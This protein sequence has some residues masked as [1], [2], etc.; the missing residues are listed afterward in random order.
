MTKQ[1]FS[2]FKSGLS[3]SDISS[4]H[5]TPNWDIPEARTGA[6]DV[7]S[8][9]VEE[10]ARYYT[11]LSRPKPSNNP[12]ILIDALKTKGLKDEDSKK[13]ESPLTLEEVKKAMHSMAKGKSPGPDGLGAEFYHAFS[14]MVAPRLHQMLLEAQ[15]EGK[16]PESFAAG[17]ISVLYKKGDPRDVRNYRP[18]TLLQVDYKIYSKVLVKRMKTVIDAFVSKE[19]LGF[20]PNRNIAEA[21]HLT[22]LIQNYLD[23]KNEDG[24]LLALDWEKAF[25]RCSW[26]YYHSALE[27][28]NFGPKFRRMLLLLAN[29]DSPA[30]RNVK[31]NGLRS[32]TYHIHCGVPQGCPFSPLAF[33]VVA[34]ALTRLILTS[35]DFHGITIGSINHRISQFADDTT[36]FARD[37][38]DACHIWPILDLYEAATGMRANA[39]K[40]LG[41]QMG[42]LKN[43]SPPPGFGPNGST[44][45]MLEDGKFGKILGIPF[46]KSGDEDTYWRGLYRKIKTR[47]ASWSTKS[48]LTIHARVQL[49]NLICYGIPRYWIQSIDPPD[50]FNKEIK[51]DIEKLIWDRQIDFDPDQ[52]GSTK[53][54]RPWIK[55]TAIYHPKRL[56]E[57]GEG[58]GL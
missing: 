29:P 53:F 47:M 24:L 22:K 30:S 8:E 4:L 25:D 57:K 52:G 19:Q 41:I 23:D 33:L 46:W 55:K 43:K 35:E 56:N 14:S 20:V 18:I 21:T 17:D 54:S 50:W 38:N 34:E 11:H 10:F 48:F 13:L 37:Y 2:Q 12:D 28:L 31:I 51:E 5:T 9:I 15:D 44:I 32:S 42:S 3:N 39:T 45:E 7:D 27:A 1:F 49:A 58:L 26:Q 40:F 6:T 16:F 36:I